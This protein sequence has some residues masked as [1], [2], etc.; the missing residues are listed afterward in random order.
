MV[1]FRLIFASISVWNTS[2]SAVALFF[3][4]FLIHVFTIVHHI[5]RVHR[6]LN[7]ACGMS[8]TLSSLASSDCRTWMRLRSKFAFHPACHC[9]SSCHHVI[10]CIHLHTVAA[11]MLLIQCDFDGLK[12]LDL[13]QDLDAL[14]SDMR[15]SFQQ[16]A[17][18]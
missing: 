10:P 11:L 15:A 8:L 6:L 17:V 2:Q 5:H 13:Q 7:R 16:A 14:W 3:Y 18:A 9:M 1:T 12:L 4:V